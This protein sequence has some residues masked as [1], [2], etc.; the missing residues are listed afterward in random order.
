VANKNQLEIDR[1]QEF[2]D[3]ERRAQ[4][5]GV[6]LMTLF[7]LAGAVGLFGSG[8]A[9]HAQQT[10]DRLRV[11]YE[12]FGRQTV[13][14]SLDITVATQARDGERVS[15]RVE[16]EFFN[17]VSLLEVRPS[18]AHIALDKDS[19]IFEVPAFGGQAHLELHYEP[20]KTGTL[21]ATI[22]VAGG[23]SVHVAQFVYF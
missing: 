17:R 8:V 9:S 19:A 23:G 20:E 21:Q 16:R 1:P 18:N 13:R 4:R 3:H 12:R 22:A 11:D 14:S 2:I 5:V 15:V 10:G 6:V 7:A